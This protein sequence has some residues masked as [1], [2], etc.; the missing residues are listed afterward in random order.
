MAPSE[1]NQKPGSGASDPKGATTMN[2]QATSKRD[3]FY[4]HMSVARSR[5]GLT[6]CAVGISLSAIAGIAHLSPPEDPTGA[7]AIYDE[8]VETYNRRVKAIAQS[9]PSLPI[10]ARAKT[11]VQA[12][13]EDTM[14]AVIVGG[15]IA[16]AG[17]VLSCCHRRNAR[18]RSSPADR[19]L[20]KAS[21]DV[22]E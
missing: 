11:R 6:L 18:V 7:G 8:H 5:L 14:F 4:R 10:L 12:H 3:A 19:P 1:A 13:R 9:N 2:R 22:I 20:K 15:V 17:I 21:N 16:A